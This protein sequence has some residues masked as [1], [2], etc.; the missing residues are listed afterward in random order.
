[1]KRIWMFIF[2]LTIISVTAIAQRPEDS[3][4]LKRLKVEKI[5][6]LAVQL[7]LTPEEAQKFW[8]VYNEFE[9]KRFK[10][11]F[12][13]REIERQV[14]GDLDSITDATLIKL[15]DDFILSHEQETQLI[16]DYHTKFLQVLPIRKVV[17]LYQAERQFRSHM[18]R[19][20]RRRGGNNESQEPEK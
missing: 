20:F 19:E 17:Q 18:L 10:L 14:N 2:V 7:Q 9:R 12:N 4:M 11:E 6:F 3:G 13:R 16:K 8:P 5:T 1:M 15:G